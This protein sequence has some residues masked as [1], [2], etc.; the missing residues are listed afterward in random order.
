MNS[1]ASMSSFSAIDMT[2]SLFSGSVAKGETKWKNL[3]FCMD[4]FSRVSL[5]LGAAL[6]FGAYTILT[7]LV[8]D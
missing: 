7:V 5:N 1:T 8:N 2:K 4:W 6:V 3:P